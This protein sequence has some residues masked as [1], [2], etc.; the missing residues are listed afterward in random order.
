MEKA[1]NKLFVCS[2]N[3]VEHQLVMSYFMDDKEVYCSV[4]LKPESNVLKRIWKAVKYV[5]GHRSVYG[6]FD[7][8]IFKPEDADSLQQIV[9]YLNAHTLMINERERASSIF[10]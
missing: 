1:I 7:E 4:H 2:C 9:D 3:S 5:F 8:F 10:N 6:D